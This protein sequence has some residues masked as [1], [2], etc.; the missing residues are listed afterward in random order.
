MIIY[1]LLEMIW[2]CDALFM[3]LLWY[4]IIFLKKFL[5]WENGV[6]QWRTIITW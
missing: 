3:C 1:S 6:L 4:M 5:R 2:E